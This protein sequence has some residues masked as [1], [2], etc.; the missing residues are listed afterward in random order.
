[1]KTDKAKK[2]GFRDKG[3]AGDASYFEDILLD[4]PR[5]LVVKLPHILFVHN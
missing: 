1:V 3:Y 5:L 2:V 4:D